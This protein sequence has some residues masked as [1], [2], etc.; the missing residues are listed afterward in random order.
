MIGIVYAT[1]HG[2]TAKIAKVINAYIGDCRLMNLKEI[3]HL[4]L[5]QCD[6]IVLGMPVYNG[7]L[8]RDMVDY[9]NH[10]QAFLIGKNYSIYITA[11][12]FSEF[13]H[14]VTEEFNYDILKNVKVIAGLGGAIYYPDLSI[15][16]KARLSL[17]NSVTRIV[18]KEHNATIYE[19]FNDEE[20]RIF[21]QKIKRIDD[22]AQ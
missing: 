18:P 20:I 10:N 11:L 17:L 19:N 7:K 3:D 14:Y 5:A 6:T 13:M 4:V 22:A 15:G 2:S 1:R 8:D 9:I 16:E 21:A 12:F